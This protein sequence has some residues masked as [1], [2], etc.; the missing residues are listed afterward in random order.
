MK[1]RVVAVS[2]LAFLGVLVVGAANWSRLYRY[3]MPVI[4]VVASYGSDDMS[5]VVGDYSIRV[6]AHLRNDGGD[7][8]AVFEATVVQGDHQWTKTATRRLGAK[9]TS[10]VEILFEEVG[11][12]MGV[13]KYTCRA[14]PLGSR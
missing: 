10:R 12:L 6:W 8:E 3:L 5:S 14:Y 9:E 1:S 4:P 11:F 13:P 7:G 2:A